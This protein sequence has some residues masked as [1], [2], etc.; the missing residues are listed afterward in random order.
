ME[1]QALNQ[2]HKGL[3][4]Y[5]IHET[6]RSRRKLLKIFLLIIAAVILYGVII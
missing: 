1:H 3:L 5:L 6:S 4:Q 2:Y